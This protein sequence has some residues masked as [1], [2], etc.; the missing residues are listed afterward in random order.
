VREYVGDA[1]AAEVGHPFWT[2]VA[3]FDL[4]DLNPRN[5]HVQGALDSIGTTW[6]ELVEQIDSPVVRAT[7]IAEALLD[8]GR[9]DEGDGGWAKDILPHGARVKWWGSKRPTGWGYLEDEDRECR[10]MLREHR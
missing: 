2:R 3:W 9:G 1:E 5:A 8:Y 10:Q 4:D 7:Y 6:D